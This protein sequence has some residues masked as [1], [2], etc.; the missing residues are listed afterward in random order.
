MDSS[1]K[2]VCKTHEEF[3]ILRSEGN[4]YT[5]LTDDKTEPPKREKPGRP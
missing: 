3:L 2:L 4:P 5:T 1:G